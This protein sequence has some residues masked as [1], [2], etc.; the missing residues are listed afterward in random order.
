V[1]IYLGPTLGMLFAAGIL[2][3][4]VR[5]KTRHHITSIADFI[6]SRYAKSISV[7]ASVTLML[8]VGIL[9]YVALQLKS[10]TGTFDLIRHAPAAVSLATSY[11]SPLVV[12]LTI[13][14]TIAF[15]IRRLDPTERHPG[16]MVSLA[17]ESLVKL[18]AFVAAGLF[19]V[20][21]FLGG[22]SG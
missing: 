20:F 5:L 13:V 22:G 6:S 10:I 9:P 11:F 1:T 2:R 8:M 15:G 16:M 4:L 17:L 19:V 7:A 12:G 18:V 3:R 21:N 14:F